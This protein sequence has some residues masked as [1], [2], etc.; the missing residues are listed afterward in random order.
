MA[1]AAVELLL[2][3]KVV[4]GLDEV[5]PVEVGVDAED[6][7]EDE[8]AGTGHLLGKATSASKPFLGAAKLLDGS[9]GVL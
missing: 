3:I 6:L 2:E 7:A 1:E 4:K 5:I 8:L 9:A